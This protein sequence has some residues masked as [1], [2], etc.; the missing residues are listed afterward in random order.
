MPSVYAALLFPDSPNY[1][2]SHD[3]IAGNDELYI[4]RI[5]RH[6]PQDIVLCDETTVV[7]VWNISFSIFA[8]CVSIKLFF[9]LRKQTLMLLTS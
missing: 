6:G 3:G 5:L 9:W 7:K 4:D 1:S 8:H 2:P